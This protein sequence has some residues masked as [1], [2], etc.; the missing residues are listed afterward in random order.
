[1]MNPNLYMT[2]SKENGCLLDL[3][4][5]VVITAS[6]LVIFGPTDIIMRNDQK[7]YLRCIK[8]GKNI[9]FKQNCDLLC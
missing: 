5:D 1:M 2:H 7:V 4:Y 3:A 8:L 9:L 6:M